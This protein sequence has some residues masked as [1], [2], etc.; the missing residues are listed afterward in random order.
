MIKKRKDGRLLKTISINGKRYYFYG[1]TERKINKNRKA[2]S[3]DLAFSYLLSK[4]LS[5]KS[6]NFLISSVS[7][8]S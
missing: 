5:A 1:K 2:K 7:L 8:G 3:F 4:S 6:Q